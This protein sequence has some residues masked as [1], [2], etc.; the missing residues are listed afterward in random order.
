MVCG[1]KPDSW[2]IKA[3][4]DPS[5]PPFLVETLSAPDTVQST[6]ETVQKI[7]LL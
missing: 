7:Y 3:D 6:G 2:E 5:A 1:F 4:V